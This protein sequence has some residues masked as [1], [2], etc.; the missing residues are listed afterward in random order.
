MSTSEAL[1]AAQAARDAAANI[2]IPQEARDRAREL[3]WEDGLIELAL[4]QG[5]SLAEVW[6]A[7]R[8][9]IDGATAKQ[10]LAGGGSIARPDFWWMKV[11]TEWGI[12]ARASDPEMGLTIGD[13]NI[14]TYGDIPDVW[15]NRSEI[16]RGSFPTPTVEDM[17]YTIYDKALIWAD[18]C[19]PL[20][21]VAIRDRWVSSTDLR[22]NSLEP[23]P[24]DIEKAVCQLMTEQ[25]ERAYYQGALLSGWL[26]EISY[27]YL[28]L[29]LFLST[30][31][32]DV[33]R[34]AEAFRKRALSNGGGL[35][36]QAPTDYNRV[37]QE[38]RT[39]P[40]LLA[41]MFV[42]DSMLLT[43]FKNGDKIAQNQLERDMYAL[44]ARDRQ[45]I[46][47]YQIERM[48]HFLWKLPDRRDEQNLYF[49]KAEARMVKEWGDSVV[50]EPLAILLGGGK[51]R[52]DSGKA[53]LQGLRKQQVQD[54]VANLEKATFFRSNLNARFKDLIG[55]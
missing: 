28:E 41:T 4:Q 27:G 31:I 29:K 16:A 32:Y 36:L 20:Y 5:H 10:F 30:V 46:M 11:P 15:Y 53:K 14:G 21:E 48:K 44:C 34:H 12:K 23:L 2:E 54:Y 50:W 22:W 19:V 52:M 55:G 18:C 40:E 37:L 47:D 17:G 1:A 13:L 38:C 33:A 6:Q 9:N 3:A 25:S 26:P 24:D 43:L 45:R 39:F 35:G 49:G 51:D 8:G 42:Q 7:L